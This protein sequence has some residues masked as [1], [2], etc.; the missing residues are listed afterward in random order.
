M[1]EVP[2]AKHKDMVKAVPS[3]RADQPFCTPV[4]PGRP[5]CDRSIPYAHCSKPE[6]KGMA[7][8]TITVANDVPRRLLPPIGFRQ[9]T[10]NPL[11][12]RVRG[13][14]QPQK[15]AATMPQDQ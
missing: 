11:C 14:T 6:H 3:D 10:G 8:N 15:L 13:D 5:G 7:V 12:V 4:L 2:L 1:K 9:L